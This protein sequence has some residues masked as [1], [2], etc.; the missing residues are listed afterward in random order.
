MVSN[1]VVPAIKRWKIYLDKILAL[2]LGDE[3]L[4]LRSGEGVDQASLG[5]NEQQDLGAG[6]N[7]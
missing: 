6:Q 7:G 4:E 2:S 1:H 3:W 5:D